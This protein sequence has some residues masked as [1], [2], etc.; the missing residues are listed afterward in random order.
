M[1]SAISH[2]PAPHVVGPKT[3]RITRPTSQIPESLI[4]E[5]RA[6]KREPFNPTKHL[7]FQPP[8][9]VVSMKDIGLE[10]HGIGPNAVSD[11]FP[12]FSK[13]AIAQ[14]RAEI[15]SEDSL[16]ECRYSS[17]FISNMIRGMG[18]K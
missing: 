12:L 18:A 16:R 4:N 15:F 17:S 5:A 3:K 1:P 9:N 13:E 7:N 8:V 11:P 14:M 2:P 10:G 6:T